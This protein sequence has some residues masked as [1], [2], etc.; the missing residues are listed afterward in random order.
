MLTPMMI[1]YFW[2]KEIVK[3]AHEKLVKG[4]WTPKQ[5][6]C[7]LAANA[8]NKNYTEIVLRHAMNGKRYRDAWDNR[9][10]DPNT[11]NRMEQD[12][13]DKPKKYAMAAF[14]SVWE[15]NLPL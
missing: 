12:R 8:V 14:P 1:T 6:R 4:D 10:E 2:L 3:A 11:Y 5:T 7:F 9:E 13:Q 15:H